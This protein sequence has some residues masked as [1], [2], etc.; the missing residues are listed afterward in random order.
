MDPGSNWNA[1][2][3]DLSAKDLAA[4]RAKL[5]APSQDLVPGPGRV[6]HRPV[7]A[8]GGT[9]VGEALNILERR[10]DIPNWVTVES[11]ITVTGGPARRP[12]TSR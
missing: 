11:P 10:V 8:S 12:P 2:P 5:Q 6:L 9:T 3:G 7:P 4:Y 1:R